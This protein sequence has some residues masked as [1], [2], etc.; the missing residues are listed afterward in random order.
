MWITGGIYSCPSRVSKRP[1]KHTSPSTCVLTHRGK[2]VLLKYSRHVSPQAA[3]R[4]R[5]SVAA[6]KTIFVYLQEAAKW[7]WCQPWLMRYKC[8]NITR[9][10]HHFKLV[11][12]IQRAIFLLIGLLLLLLI[13]HETYPFLWLMVNNCMLTP[14]SIYSKCGFKSQAIFNGKIHRI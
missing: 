11:N 8:R 12:Q 3:T 13:F 2:D 7:W 10:S 9:P 5:C 14:P 6:L 4:A 1:K